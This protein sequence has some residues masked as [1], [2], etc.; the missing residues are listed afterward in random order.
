MLSMKFTHDVYIIWQGGEGRGL[1]KYK[2][3]IFKGK[4]SIA[5]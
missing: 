3:L 1:C 4:T 5:M 2:L